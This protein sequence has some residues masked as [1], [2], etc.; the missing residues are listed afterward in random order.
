MAVAVAAAAAPPDLGSRGG[1][2]VLDL[3][4]VGLLSRLWSVREFLT[5]NLSPD[6]MVTE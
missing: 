4:G 1:E 6:D 2:D 3:A 5:G